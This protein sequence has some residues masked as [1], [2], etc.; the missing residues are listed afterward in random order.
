MSITLAGITFWAF[1]VLGEVFPAGTGNDTSSGKAL[2]LV[3][4]P[5]TVEADVLEVGYGY[6]W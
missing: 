6:T 1:K 5:A 3:V 4:Y 2:R